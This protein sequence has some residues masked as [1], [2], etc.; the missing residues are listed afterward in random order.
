MV[1]PV[2]RNPNRID[3][4]VALM[5]DTH[6][7]L[8][9]WVGPVETFMTVD[10]GQGLRACEDIEEG[11][12]ILVDRAFAKA[13]F[14]KTYGLV[15]KSNCSK[16]D[17]PSTVK[18]KADL[19]HQAHT[20]GVVS[21]ILELLVDGSKNK[22]L[23]PLWLLMRTLDSCQL[24]LPGLLTYTANK[25]TTLTM[26]NIHAI[27]DMNI[28]EGNESSEITN[29]QDSLDSTHWS[30]WFNGSCLFSLISTM[31]HSNNPNC[32]Y[33]PTKNN[34]IALIMTKRAITKVKSFV[35]NTLTMIKLRPF[36]GNA[37]S[38]S[39][40]EMV[41]IIILL[42][43]LVRAHLIIWFDNREIPSTVIWN[44]F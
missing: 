32:R 28:H 24:L 17:A 40:F 42:L 4:L 16:Y 23:V 13:E 2:V 11:F 7:L 43:L 12:C 18:L 9:R 10:K 22:P 27:V 19:V 6:L 15:S 33:V 37:N 38:H 8:C 44:P 30:R 5:V 21:D 25:H 35:S 3:H 14:D 39:F 34:S 26:E 1:Y 41:C 20:D 36:V 31:N 29:K